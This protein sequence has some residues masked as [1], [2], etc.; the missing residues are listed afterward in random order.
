MVLM[1]FIVG[2][3]FTSCKPDNGEEP[4]KKL[5]KFT[6]NGDENILKYDDQGH[7]IECENFMGTKSLE[8][9]DDKL[10]T[11]H[12]NSSITTRNESYTYE[13]N[14][15]TKGYNPIIPYTITAYNC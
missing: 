4:T 5:V 7:L 9:N 10:I 11:I 13:K 2:V 3:S 14:Y 6:F 8:W 12:V 1:A 15:I